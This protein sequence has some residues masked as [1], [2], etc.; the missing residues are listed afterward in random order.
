MQTEPRTATILGFRKK[1]HLAS[2]KNFVIPLFDSK[3]IN[4]ISRVLYEEDMKV[5]EAVSLNHAVTAVA[6]GGG[7]LLLTSTDMENE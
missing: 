4:F 7:R 2:V 6:V 1:S 3:L 5:G